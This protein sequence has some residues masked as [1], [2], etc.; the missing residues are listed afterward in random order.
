MGNVGH[1]TKSH[2]LDGNVLVLFRHAA[3]H[4]GI[5]RWQ[6]AVSAVADASAMTAVLRIGCGIHI[7]AIIVLRRV[8]RSRVRKGVVAVGL[9]ETDRGAVLVNPTSRR[10]GRVRRGRGHLRRSEKR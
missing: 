6:N 2:E 4:S 8:D 7:I 1:F 5:G 3:A 9:V 10:N